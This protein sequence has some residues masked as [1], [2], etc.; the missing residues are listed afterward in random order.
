MSAV[1][2]TQILSNWNNRVPGMDQSSN[3][4]YQGVEAAIAAE[5][6]PDVK[7]E[8]VN[9]AEGGMLSAKREYLQVRRKELVF[10]ICAAPYGTGFFLSWWLG[11]VQSGILVALSN[12]PFIGFIFRFLAAASKPMTYYR[13]DTAMMFQSVVHGSVMS[14]LDEVMNAKGLRA[15]SETERKP[16]MRDFFAQ[17]GGGRS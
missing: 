3:E 15:L 10:H 16:V 11:E 13:I 1:T 8:R 5:K 14:T 12:L 9:I 6:L 4:F 17:L 7:C 2:P